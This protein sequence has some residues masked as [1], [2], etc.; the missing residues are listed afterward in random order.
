MEAIIVNCAE[1]KEMILES[2]EKIVEKIVSY[3]II[4]LSL[5]NYLKLERYR[6]FSYNDM[7]MVQKKKFKFSLSRDVHMNVIRF[8]HS[9]VFAYFFC[10]YF[11]YVQRTF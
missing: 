7:F 2:N 8:S 3:E 4:K 1:W 11:E 6:N 5:L 9:S 10:Y